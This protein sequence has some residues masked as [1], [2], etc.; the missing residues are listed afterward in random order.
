MRRLVALISVAAAFVIV[1]GGTAAPPSPSDPAGGEL[2][3]VPALPAA[4]HDAGA[5]G[6]G[7]GANLGYHGGPVMHTNTT[8]AIYWV[9]PGYSVSA[10][11][12]SLINRF[13][14]DVANDSGLS[15]NVYFA[16]TQY[17]DSVNGTIAY[18]S[19]FG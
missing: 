10:N 9:P 16:G 8:Y 11:Y 13:F 2:G 15:S 5:H 12:E 4:A 18:N 6:G 1:A 3:V 19:T 7:A 14:A 17:Y